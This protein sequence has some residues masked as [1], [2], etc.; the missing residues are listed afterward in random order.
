MAKV[1][2]IERCFLQKRLGNRVSAIGKVKTVT[3]KK[4][5]TYGYIN[6]N[7]INVL[8]KPI[9]IVERLFDHLW[10]SSNKLVFRRNTLLRFSGKVYG[11]KK[12][13]R[14]SSFSLTKIG[15]VEILSEDQL[16]EDFKRKIK[17]F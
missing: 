5:I 14:N 6:N 12:W 4:R 1:K 17:N 13:N 15:D 11:Y 8:F 2:K 10:I 7:V 3:N 16:T 9:Q